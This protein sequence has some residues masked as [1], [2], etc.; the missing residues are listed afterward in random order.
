MLVVF[1]WLQLGVWF[2]DCFSF[3]FVYSNLVF[4][5]LFLLVS[6][7]VMVIAC[8]GRVAIAC[9]LRVAVDVC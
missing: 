5:L 4:T 3:W 9:G 6:G 8:Y 1:C 7:A 2:C